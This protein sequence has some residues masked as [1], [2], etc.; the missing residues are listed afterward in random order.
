MYKDPKAFLDNLAAKMAAKGNKGGG[1]TG[2]PPAG[3]ALRFNA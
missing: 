2:A 3:A 1:A